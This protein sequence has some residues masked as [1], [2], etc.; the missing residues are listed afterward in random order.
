[1]GICLQPGELLLNGLG[2]CLMER[3]DAGIDRY[4]HCHDRP[5]VLMGNWSPPVPVSL[6]ESSAE[7][8]DR[9]DP[10]VGGRREVSWSAAVSAIAVFSWLPPGC[11]IAS[12]G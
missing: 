8:A 6:L 12:E 2:M 10:N 11:A 4:S 3:R 1:M 9:L 7:G 5:P